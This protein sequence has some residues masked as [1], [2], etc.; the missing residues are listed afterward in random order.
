MVNTVLVVVLICLP[1]AFV[2]ALF[3]HG[4]LVFARAI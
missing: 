3:R 1:A 4:L 2:H